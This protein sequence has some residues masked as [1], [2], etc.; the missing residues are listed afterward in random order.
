MYKKVERLLIHQG[1]GV[2]RFGGCER[3]QQMLFDISGN[4]VELANVVCGVIRY[5]PAPLSS[6]ARQ[7]HK[8]SSVLPTQQS[9]ALTPQSNALIS[10]L[11]TS[12]LRL[13]NLIVAMQLL[14][15]APPATQLYSIS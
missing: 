1:G 3:A 11:S 5:P 8:K 4:A 13:P 6:H 7:H 12:N 9:A 10:W 14:E 15:C 2:R